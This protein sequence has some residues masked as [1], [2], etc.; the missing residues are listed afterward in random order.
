ME[1]GKILLSDLPVPKGIIN[2][3][4]YVFFLLCCL[5]I[6][7]DPNSTNSLSKPPPSPSPVIQPTQPSGPQV[8]PQPVQPTPQMTVQPASPPLQH[9]GSTGYINEMHRLIP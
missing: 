9:Q 2:P 5:F 6:S 3:V 4:P 1:G 7:L 8:S